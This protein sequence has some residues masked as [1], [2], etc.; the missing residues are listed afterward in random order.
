M[1]VTTISPKA[2]KK[3]PKMMLNY[4]R[5]FTKFGNCLTAFQGNS[6]C[7][8]SFYDQEPPLDDLK[9]TWA[10]A[11]LTEND[12]LISS[13]MTKLFDGTANFGI[14]LKGTDF[15]VEVWEA[16]LKLE[17]GTTAN[18]EDVAK[19]LGRPKSVRAVAK[20]VGKNNVAYFVPCHRVVRKDGS[21]S[22]YRW[23]EQRKVNILRDEGAM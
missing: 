19:S 3:L 21:V 12:A 8:M 5:A 11:I 9:K 22:K 4:G 15:E 17:K 16:I 20:A 1:Q 2:Y 6:L 7:Y 18:Y 14:Y 13:N 23:G 10:N